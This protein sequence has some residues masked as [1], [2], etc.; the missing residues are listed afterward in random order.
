MML[1][2]LT[3]WVIGGIKFRLVVYYIKKG[4]YE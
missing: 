2:D 3:I 4:T 1:N